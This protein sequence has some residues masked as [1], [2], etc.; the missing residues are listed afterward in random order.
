MEQ[1][2]DVD[3]KL[4]FFREPDN[5]HDERVIVIKKADGIKIGEIK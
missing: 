1:F 3:G 4:E 2:M 5:P